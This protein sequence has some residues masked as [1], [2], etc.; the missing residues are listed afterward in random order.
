MTAHESQF[1][2]RL[3]ACL[4]RAGAYCLKLHGHAM[5]APGWPDVMVFHHTWTGGLELKWGRNALTQA[6]RLV[7]EKLGERGF[8]FLVLREV[9]H[10]T[11]MVEQLDGAELDTVPCGPED[12]PSL[13]GCLAQLTTRFGSMQASPP[14]MLEAGGY[15]YRDGPRGLTLEECRAYA[16]G[17]R[18]LR[19]ELRAKGVEA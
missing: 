15:S 16:S 4:T 2:A 5:Q 6:Q 8:P 12:G 19:E 13:L 17:R 1:W 14:A 11:A 7:G 10:R 9:T 18:S 3:R